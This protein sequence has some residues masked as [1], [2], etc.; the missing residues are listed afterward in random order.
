VYDAIDISGDVSVSGSVKLEDKDT[1]AN[2]VEVNALRALKVSGDIRLTDNIYVAEIDS[3]G[4]LV[5]IPIEHHKIHEGNYYTVTDYSG[6]VAVAVSAQ[7]LVKTPDTTKRAH[8]TSMFDSSGAAAV[9]LYEN[10]TVV[11]NGVALTVINNNRNSLNTATVTVFRRPQTSADR[12]L[13]EKRFMGTNN[14]RTKLGGSA[15]AA[16]EYM[17]K[18]NEDYLFKYTP[19]GDNAIVAV[20][21][22][23][24]EV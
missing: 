18:Q 11:A 2:K 8:L 21:I 3:L 22:E 7:W 20:N 14:N 24:Y 16:S 6:D 15:R 12:T 17:L 4:Y 9:E 13:L 19:S 23:F 10:P 5:T 1:S